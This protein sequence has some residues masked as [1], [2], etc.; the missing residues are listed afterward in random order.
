ML[1][2]QDYL[3]KFGA[4]NSSQKLLAKFTEVCLYA[5]EH[6]MNMHTKEITLYWFNSIRKWY[7]KQVLKTNVV[8]Q[9]FQDVI[10]TTKYIFFWSQMFILS[11]KK[12]HLISYISHPVVFKFCH[13]GVIQTIQ[14][15]T[16]EKVNH[17]PI[18]V[19]LKILVLNRR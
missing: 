9:G 6:F 13:I 15:I 8:Y 17:C 19:K 5:Q 7:D 18:F 14:N 10:Q 4:L 16:K 2:F 1:I 12:C 11:N 3:D